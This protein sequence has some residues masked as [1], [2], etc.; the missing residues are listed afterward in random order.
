MNWMSTAVMHYCT[1]AAG[2][3]DLFPPCHTVHERIKIKRG[4]PNKII[5]HENVINIHET[6]RFSKKSL[7]FLCVAL[8]GGTSGVAGRGVGKYTYSRWPW[9]RNNTLCS[10]LKSCFSAEI[11]TKIYL[12]MH[13]FVEKSLLL[14]YTIT[15]FY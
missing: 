6:G 2:M 7:H 13:Y 3:L 11:Y 12:K 1:A 10:K 14:L 15:P 4:Y 8:R 5:S 9:G